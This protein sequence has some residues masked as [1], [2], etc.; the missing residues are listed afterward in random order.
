MYRNNKKNCIKI[1]GTAEVLI[2]VAAV[3]KT[4]QKK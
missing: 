2:I 4:F 3:W 1:N